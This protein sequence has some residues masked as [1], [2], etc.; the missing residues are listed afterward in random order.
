MTVIDTNFIIALVV[1]G[2]SIFTLGVFVYAIWKGR[3]SLSWPCVDGVI[4]TSKIQREWKWCGSNKTLFITALIS[5]K[6]SVN[7][8]LYYNDKIN[9]SEVY[10]SGGTEAKRVTLK[11]PVD[12]KVKVFYS[13]NDPKIAYLEPGYG[14]IAGFI[15]LG[16]I[17]IISA[18]CGI[19]MFLGIIKI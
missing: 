12:T 9:I 5:Y 4:T 1:S 19:L 15:F 11:Y 6:Y 13:P 7:D 17:S 16:F 18:A 3:Q 2:I 14:N 8:K 10:D